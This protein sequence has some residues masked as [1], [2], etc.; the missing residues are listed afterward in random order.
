MMRLLYVFVANEKLNLI[1]HYI[2]LKE[3]ET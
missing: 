3:K 1:V 2:I